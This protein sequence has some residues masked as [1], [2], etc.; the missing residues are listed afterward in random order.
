[1]RLLGIL[2]RE[3]SVD[4][5][6][7]DVVIERKHAEMPAFVVVPAA[8]V[9]AWALRATT[10]VEGTLD[11]VPIGRR[12]L[13]RWDDDRWFI[14][15]RRGVLEVVAKSSGDRATLVIAIAS[16]EL[17][18]ELQTLIDTVPEARGAG[19]LAP[20]LR[21]GCSARRSWLRRRL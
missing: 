13:Q 2:L 16:G 4:T 5:V 6:N 10:T 11:G 9:A 14:E 20:L 12:S 21:S 17:S 3:T 1:M 7:L 15:L 18:A 8:G 19:R